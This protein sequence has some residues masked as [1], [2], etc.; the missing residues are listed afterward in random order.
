MC[1]K[2]SKVLFEEFAEN[3]RKG[4]E[5]HIGQPCKEETEYLIKEQIQYQLNKFIQ[6][7]NFILPIS[8]QRYRITIPETKKIII[9]A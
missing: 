9:C 5:N 7:N 3:I 2:T 4:L 1:L 8:K 6:L